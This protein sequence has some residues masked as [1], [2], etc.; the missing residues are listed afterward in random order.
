MNADKDI[1]EF[2]QVTLEN[3]KSNHKVH[4]LSIIGEIEGHDVLSSNTKATKYEHILPKLAEIEDDSE[5][6]ED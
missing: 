6:K 4:L 1:K 5:E 3:S 2:G